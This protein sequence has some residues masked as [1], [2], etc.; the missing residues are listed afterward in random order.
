LV[1]KLKIDIKMKSDPGILNDI[2]K[3]DM[4]LADFKPFTDMLGDRL[5]VA[6]DLR[7]LLEQ[8]RTGILT[9]HP[10]INEFCSAAVDDNLLPK[11]D[12]EHPLITRTIH[13]TYLL[14]TLLQAMMKDWKFMTDVHDFVIAKRTDFGI[15]PQF[16]QSALDVFRLTGGL[17]EVAKTKT[18]DADFQ[19]YIEVR[20]KGAVSK[21]DADGRR[22]ALPLNISEAVIA[23]FVIGNRDNS[24][25]GA[26]LAA[27]RIKNVSISEGDRL[28]KLELSQEWD[29]LYETWN[30]AFITSY[31]DYLHILYPKL[32]APTVM[33]AEPDDYIFARGMG[34]WLSI[35]FGLFKKVTKTPSPILPGK[36]ALAK[37]W[38]A[39]NRKY[40]AAL[41]KKEKGM[42]LRCLSSVL[43]GAMRSP[44]K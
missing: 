39:I 38:G 6:Q 4:Y 1:E 18:K 5:T 32:L 11:I 8:I 28:L 31:L 15:R 10:A 30:L 35:N 3:N 37:K 40:A 2:L 27:I 26:V 44:P 36:M 14:D 29:S 19:K 34:L 33:N 7:P 12:Q 41:F 22:K 16:F 23:D 25:S 20:S 9:K 24:L 21:K 13:H 42:E 17:F 43:M